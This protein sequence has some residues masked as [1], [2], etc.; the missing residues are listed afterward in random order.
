M[1][2]WTWWMMLAAVS[3]LSALAPSDGHAQPPKT[4]SFQGYLEDTDGPLEAN[5]SMTFSLY[6]GPETD[7]SALLLWTETHPSVAVGGGIFDVVLGSA[8]SPLDLPFDAQYYL[9][10]AVGTDDELVP[11]Q[12]LTSIGSALNADTVD[13]LHAAAFAPAAHFHEGADIDSGVVAQGQIDPAIARLTD[14]TWSNLTGVPAGLA[15]GDDVGLTSETDPLWTASDAFP[16]TASD[17]ESWNQAAGW[18]DH[19][20]AGYDTTDDAWTGTGDVYTTSGRVGIGTPS[21][22]A[23]LDVARAAGPLTGMLHVT[24]NAGITGL[25]VDSFNRV[26]IRTTD[27]DRELNLDGTMVIDSS[28]GSNGILWRT[29]S[30]ALIN[31]I[32]VSSSDLEMGIGRNQPLRIEDLAPASSVHIDSTGNVGIGESAPSTAL[33]VD[34]DLSTSGYVQLALTSGTPPAFDCD[35]ASERGRMKVDSGAGTLYVCVDVGWVAK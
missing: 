7:A 31:G 15:D 2:A 30:T 27:M 8:G 21:P 4:M 18:G 19:A 25:Y 1:S 35:E 29:P 5:V 23:Q 22:G 10:I 14:V 9:G 34:G 26:G 28:A 33:D 16:I 13:G 11:R 20:A 32:I 3:I 12:P 6:D 17:I 24:G